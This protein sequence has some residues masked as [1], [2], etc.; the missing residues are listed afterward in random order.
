MRRRQSQSRWRGATVREGRVVWQLADS[1]KTRSDGTYRFGLLAEGDYAL[2]SEP[3]MDS[4]LDL[5]SGG[6]GQRWGYASVYYPDAREPSGVGRIHVA[7]G[8]DAQANFTLMREPFEMVTAAVLFP[9][10]TR[11]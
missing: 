8:Q 2:F 11:R 7:N 1:T 9:Q 4:D 10:G 6:A 5:A 3:A